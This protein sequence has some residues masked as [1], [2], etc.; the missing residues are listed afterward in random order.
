MFENINQ[1]NSITIIDIEETGKALKIEFQEDFKKFY[2]K[3]NGGSPIQDKYYVADYDTFITIDSFLPIK[4][5]AE[6][7]DLWTL[8]QSFEHLQSK[9]ALP[10]GLVPFA[11]DMGGNKI[12]FDADGKIYIVYMDLGNPIENPK[13]VRYLAASFS[14]FVNNLEE[15]DDDEDI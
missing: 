6:D 10:E 4:Y 1:S 15:S 13:A 3:Q 12:C 14:E 11:N 7:S 5:K 9:G 8:E 2:L